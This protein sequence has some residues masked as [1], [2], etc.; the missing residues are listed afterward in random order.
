MKRLLFFV[1]VS[2]WLALPLSA[3]QIDILFAGDAM[4]HQSQIDNAFRNNQYDYS[5]YFK[6]IQYEVS[7]ADLAVV[8]L[9]VTLAGKPYKGYPQFSAPD[10]Y[11]IALQDAGF[12]VFLTANNHVLDRGSKGLERTLS[13][14][15]TLS[16]AHT[17]VFRNDTERAQRYPL[18]IEKEGFRLA[19]LN[20]TYGTNGFRPRPP[21][22]VNYIDKEQIK[23]DIEKAKSLNVDVIIA[24]MHWGEEYKL[25]PNKTQENLAD[26]LVEAGV[27]LVIG[28]HPHVVQ[29]SEMITDSVGNNTNL[30]VY[31]LGN[32]VSGMLAA[33]TDG[34]QMIKVRL[35]KEDGQVRIE[36]AGYMLVYRH[37]ERVGNKVDFVVAP[38]SLA[39]KHPIQI[40]EA[41]LIDLDADSYRKMLIFS[42]NARK[43]L[44]KH[45]VNVPE[46]RV[47]SKAA[48][49]TSRFSFSPSYF[50]YEIGLPK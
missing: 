11:A 44:N 25:I 29:P 1:I 30:V 40:P 43:V 10:E 14:L 8:N 34:G 38:V 17:G 35:K 9:E 24:N 16:V 46:Y 47:R 37:K 21:I 6:Y 45:N 23:S 31:S 36:S 49:T 32:L 48:A 12:D 13:V 7:T 20:Y 18:L 27:D 5:S 28:S 42:G 3:Q 26:F 22:L 19:F 50:R 33:N 4:Q 39:E 15:D 2:L 41:P